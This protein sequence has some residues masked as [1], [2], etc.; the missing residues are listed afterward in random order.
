MKKMI[1][2]VVGIAASVALLAG[3]SPHSQQDRQMDGDSILMYSAPDF[4]SPVVD[5]ISPQSQVSYVTIFVKGSWYEVMNATT[6][7]VG[8]INPPP[9]KAN[10]TEVQKSLVHMQQQTQQLQQQ[11]A[12]QVRLLQQ[13]ENQMMQN[14]K[15]APDGQKYQSTS[16][17][18]NGGA[19]AQVTQTWRDKQGNLQT[20]TY[21]IPSDQ[22]SQLTI[23]NGNIVSVSS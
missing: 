18:Y 6:G 20:K 4:N 2:A 15:T 10:E 21:N 13:Q 19:T 11:F 7:Q 5:E 23:V 8:W 3:C 9:M 12:N 14:L 16:I 1:L 17:S 22:L